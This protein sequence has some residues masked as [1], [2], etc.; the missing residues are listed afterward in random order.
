MTC[1]IEQILRILIL[2]T[3]D[4]LSLTRNKI[5]RDAKFHVWNV[6]GMFDT[7]EVCLL[8]GSTLSSCKKFGVRFMLV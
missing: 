3:P 2:K 8:Q 4:G 6:R 5:F 1:Q 7:E